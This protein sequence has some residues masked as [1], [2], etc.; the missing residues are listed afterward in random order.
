MFWRFGYHP[1]SNIQQLLDRPNVT[2]EELFAEEDLLQEVKG[3]SARLLDHLSEPGVLSRL[4]DYIVAE[5]FEQLQSRYTY[6]ACEILSTEKAP[7]ATVVV[8]HPDLLEHLWGYL[9]RP[10][11]LHFLQASYFSRVM[12]TF[13][14]K[15][16][17]RILTF[18]KAQNNVVP[19]FLQHIESSA[20]TDLLLK[21]LSFEDY[22]EGTGIAEWLSSE[23]LIPRLVDLL[24]PHLD[25]DTHSMAGQVLMDIIVISQCNNPEQPSIGTNCLV[26]ELKSEPIVSRIMGYMLD[27]DAPLASSSLVNGVFIFV[28]LVRRNY[29]DAN[30][31]DTNL[32]PSTSPE[33]PNGGANQ[34]GY[35]KLMVP[36]DLSDLIRVISDRLG[37]LCY[38]LTHPRNLAAAQPS[39]VGTRQ[40]L[41]FERLRICELFAELLHC[42]NM[43]KLNVASPSPTAPTPHPMSVSPSQTLPAGSE[44]ISEPKAAS[45]DTVEN[46]SA[47]S[48]KEVA[49][50][51]GSPHRSTDPVPMSS[52]PAEPAPVSPMSTSESPAQKGAE[53][54]PFTEPPSDLTGIP[55]GQLLKWKIIE[56]RFMLTCLD[57]FFQFPWNN[58][59][60]TVVY[61]LVHQILNL[62][63]NFTCNQALV[64][65]L[66]KDAGL[67]RRITTAY[68]LNQAECEK[69]KGVRFGYMG[70]LT[71][72]SEEV[73]RLFERCTSPL[74][75]QLQEFIDDEEWQEYVVALREVKERDHCPLGGER[76]LPTDN[77]LAG[78]QDTSFLEPHS[79][80][81]EEDTRE[82][83]VDD[84]DDDDE[85][86]MGMGGIRSSNLGMGSLGGLGLLGGVGAGVEGDQ[87]VRYLSH[88]I[89]SELPE[90]LAGGSSDEDEEPSLIHERYDSGGVPRF[91]NR[92]R[93]DQ[94]DE[95]D[96][97]EED[98]ED[99]GIGW[100]NG[101][102]K[103]LVFDRTTILPNSVG[104]S[105]QMAEPLVVQ[106]SS[107]THIND[108][109]DDSVFE[110]RRSSLGALDGSDD[111][112]ED[113]D[114][115]HVSP[116]HLHPPSSLTPA[117]DGEPEVSIT[118]ISPNPQATK[119]DLP[120]VTDWS[121]DFQQAFDLPTE[122]RASPFTETIT[123]AFD[124]HTEA[125]EA[126]AIPLTDDTVKSDVQSEHSD[127]HGDNNRKNEEDDEE[128]TDFQQA[129]S[130]KELPTSGETTSSLTPITPTAT[131]KDP[132]T[133]TSQ[134]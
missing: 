62:P 115:D 73:V 25:V 61:D 20:I 55:V 3:Q 106:S 47:D 97:D 36:V 45:L 125:E 30:V 76:P 40:P 77:M 59:L 13:L 95:E 71:G 112:S 57:L 68:R 122:E 6:L 81:M 4:L 34:H 41:G 24:E 120:I 2:L 9:A 22:P 117:K 49:T 46:P 33:S 129:D 15:E 65:S 17:E 118:P 130:G 10:G 80:D 38:L 32:G 19:Q 12:C 114:V 48:A 31:T 105:V 94:R 14:Q 64:Y 21:L 53:P 83:D 109:A 128:F 99:A 92:L 35:G 123:E 127:S 89:T 69:P 52:D 42:S 5:D 86:G 100:I 78:L 104:H 26:G 110:N 84:D 37:N 79:N 96:E 107:A 132:A 67:T 16:P 75:D 58:F 8:N 103:E 98:D 56:H 119:Q 7:F 11:P 43:Y 101:Y 87:F 116:N 133:A 88:Q 28:E 44:S 51:V 113:D 121:A 111:N 50:D 66:F 27:S 85:Y 93:H 82:D 70:H 23:E 72:I 91:V 74:L 39:T 131:L 29:S 134:S 108:L 54:C 63:L 126:D 60:H 18:I 1:Q 90:H 102:R 124:F